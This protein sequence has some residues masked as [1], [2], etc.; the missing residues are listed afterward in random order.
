MNFTISFIRN[1]E[2]FK[3]YITRILDVCYTCNSVQYFFKLNSLIYIHVAKLCS[4]HSNIVWII[5]ET[6]QTV[7]CLFSAWR[8]NELVCF[9]SFFYRIK[10]EFPLLYRIYIKYKT[11]P[12]RK[13]QVSAIN[14]RWHPSSLI[15]FLS[16]TIC[17]RES[18]KKNLH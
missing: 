3:D 1:F 18:D 17:G 12:K 5:V 13:F 8:R 11:I 4:A 15:F 7:K 14:C 2:I 16:P 10:Y 6:A 9:I